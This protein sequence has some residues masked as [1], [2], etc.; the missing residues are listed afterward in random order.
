MADLQGNKADTLA[1]AFA[2]AERRKDFFFEPSSRLQ[3]LEKLEH[4]SRFSDFLL[5]LAGPAGAG[6]TVLIRQLQAVPSDRTLRLCAVDGRQTADLH[7]LL[8][9]LSQQLSP[10]LDTQA[11]N[12]TM[13]NAIYSFAQVMA[14]EHIQWVIIIDN[15]DE[16]EQSAIQLLL[17]M[18]SEAQGLP[19]KP[20]LLMAADEQFLAQLQT[21]E[22]YELLDAQVHQLILQPFTFAE[23]R[24]YLLQRY[25]AAASL[26]E[27]QLRAVYDA[28]GGYPGGLNQQVERLLQSGHVTQAVPSVALS[29]VHFS[30]IASVLLVVLLGSL[31]HYWPD[32][33]PSGN[34]T[35]VEIQLPIEAGP[36]L[37]S[38]ESRSPPV[39]RIAVEKPLVTRQPLSAESQTVELVNNPSADVAVAIESPPGPPASLNTSLEHS[40]ALPSTTQLIGSTVEPD[41][42]K[43][44][45]QPSVAPS[46]AVV[47]VSVGGI[48]EVADSEPVKLAL[49]KPIPVK[50]VVEPETVKKVIKPSAPKPKPSK[51]S[52]VV[53]PSVM[54][55]ATSQLTEAEQMLL[56]WP[57][58]GYTL[59]VLGA[60]M[61]SS[62]EQF[63][64]AQ[65]EPQKFY[66]FQT[67][68]KSKPWFVVVYG[69]YKDRSAAQTAATALP[70]ALA[71]LKPWART[72]QGIQTD[73][74]ARK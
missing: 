21:Y 13:L 27:K 57:S 37:A 19:I 2:H 67:K 45:S 38:T 66:M 11:D 54:A 56:S 46:T 25:S 32:S 33:E 16:M 22:E 53:K 42:V 24:N 36:V 63:I 30:A 4:L 61:R 8:V 29:R 65:A 12:Q 10:E 47:D 52:P 5:L 40:S 72:I 34:R 71:K 58:T 28:S 6:K 73:I 48:T 3:L 69:Q 59:Q 23:A 41:S 20:H 55:V 15:A 7:G 14:V 74:A 60:G 49:V 62:A 43:S 64:R 1:D 68:Y 31:W 70:S 51:K 44:M 17:Q 39:T 50:P 18:L 26:S 9:A 35:Q